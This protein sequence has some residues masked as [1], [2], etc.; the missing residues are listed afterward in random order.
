ML[1]FSQNRLLSSSLFVF[2]SALREHGLTTFNPPAAMASTVGPDQLP[3]HSQH[4]LVMRHGDRSDDSVDQSWWM[5]VPRPWDA[6]LAA[7]GQIRALET[8]KKLQAQLRF[9]IHR[10]ITSPFRRCIET[11][12]ELIAG[13][14]KMDGDAANV[15]AGEDGDSTDSPTSRIKVSIEYGMC[16]ILND[17]SLWYHPTGRE[18]WGFDIKQLENSFPS[19]FVDPAPHQV[20]KEP[21]SNA[22]EGVKVAASTY[23]KEARGHRIKAGYCGCAHLKR[24][25]VRNGNSFTAK[26]FEIATNPEETGIERKPL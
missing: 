12:Q 13:L 5:R 18:S 17:V 24:Q 1:C 23:W 15:V 19:G 22:G 7:A 14:S 10:V 6:P 3:S 2:P 21:A 9:P 16:E 25:I 26:R 4:V 11:A 8:G 20:Y